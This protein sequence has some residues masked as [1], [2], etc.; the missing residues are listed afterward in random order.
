MFFKSYTT[1]FHLKMS[2]LTALTVYFWDMHIMLIY[3]LM[4][5]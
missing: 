5:I 2:I 4:S 3:A 1:F